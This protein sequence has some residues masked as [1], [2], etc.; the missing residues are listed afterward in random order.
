MGQRHEFGAG[1]TALE[2]FGAEA[3]L[4]LSTH[5]RRPCGTSARADW[6][7]VNSGQDEVKSAG[8]DD[9]DAPLFSRSH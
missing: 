8:L 9:A 4:M 7:V 2:G 5:Y 3:A 1:P 6:L